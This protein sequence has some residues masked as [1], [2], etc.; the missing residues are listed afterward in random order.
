MAVYASGINN[1]KYLFR[2]LDFDF[3]SILGSGPADN[4]GKLSQGQQMQ[5]I[6]LSGL[7]R[8]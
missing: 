5:N 3:W 4:R 6:S 2:P 7:H 8:V 1:V